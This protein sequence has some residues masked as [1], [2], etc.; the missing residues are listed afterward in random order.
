M[1]PAALVVA[2][3]VAPLLAV[4][5]A[6]AQDDVPPVV[7]DEPEAVAE[8]ERTVD[9]A[10][11]DGF[12]TW[13]TDRGRIPGLEEGGFL[14]G[15]VLDRPLHARN[16][17]PVGRIVNIALDASA[18]ARFFFVRMADDTRRAVPV[19]SVMVDGEDRLFTE[20]TP[21]QVDEL[22]RI[23]PAES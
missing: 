6:G 13:L 17:E 23:A 2:A 7:A 14:A 16:G 3:T 22:P 4:G 8:G 5:G 21:A 20:L 15:E 11:Y 10:T 1:T 9:P 18:A 12:R 19:A